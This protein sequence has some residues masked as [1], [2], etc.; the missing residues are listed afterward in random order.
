MDKKVDYD[1]LAPTY[2]QRFANQRPSGVAQT[3]Q[4]FVDLHHFNAV[5]E[6]GCG[7]GHLLATSP[8]LAPAISAWTCHAACSSRPKPTTLICT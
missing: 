5:L 2:D 4:D 7:T 1:Q 6:V 8:N 3:L